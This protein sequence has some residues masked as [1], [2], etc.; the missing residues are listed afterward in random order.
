MICHYGTMLFLGIAK[1]VHFYFGVLR[2]S[3]MSCFNPL[4]TT[5]MTVG[6]VFKSLQTPWFIPSRELL[7]AFVVSTD[8]PYI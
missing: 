8:S 1:L 7:L 2:A 3:N 6:I 5:S 4:L